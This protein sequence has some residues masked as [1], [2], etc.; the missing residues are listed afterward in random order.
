MVTPSEPTS[1][2]PPHPRTPLIGREGE[3]AV[4]RELLLEEACR[5]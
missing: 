1:G 4:L 3:L 2:I 5:W